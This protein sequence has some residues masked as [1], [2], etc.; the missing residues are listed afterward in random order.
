MGRGAYEVAVDAAFGFGGEMGEAWEGSG[1]FCFVS[2]DRGQRYGSDSL[3]SSGEGLGGEFLLCDGLGYGV[4]GVLAGLDGFVRGYVAYGFGHLVWTLETDYQS[5]A[6]SLP[7]TNN[8]ENHVFNG[9]KCP[10]AGKKSD[11]NGIES[12]RRSRS[13]TALELA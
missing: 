5:A 1:S 13:S 8:H 4:Y 9:V 10:H 6:M 11:E 2:Q 7:L 3:C 12:K